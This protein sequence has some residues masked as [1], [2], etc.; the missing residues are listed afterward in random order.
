M[1][2]LAVD[3]ELTA[4]QC[5]L[6]RQLVYVF[7]G[8]GVPTG[9]KSHVALVTLLEREVEEVLVSR[10]GA[11]RRRKGCGCVAVSVF[12][13]DPW[14][15]FPGFWTLLPVTATAL[16]I[17]GGSASTSPTSRLLAS[18]PLVRGGDWS[19]SIYLWHWPFIVFAAYIW[20]ANRVAL[21]I[22]AV[23]SFALAVASD[24]WVE[25]PL[26]Q[27]DVQGRRPITPLVSLTLLP[28]LALCSFLALGSSQKRWTDWPRP[29]LAVADDRNVALERCS[30]SDFATD[31]FTPAECWEPE[32]GQVI[33]EALLL[34]DSQ[35]AA[36]LPAVV[37]A[38]A[39]S[40]LRTLYSAKPG[41]PFAD[42]RPSGDHSGFDCQ[43]WQNQSL[44]YALAA[45]PEVVVIANRSTGYTSP[46]LH[47]RVPLDAS[48]RP[49]KDV[50]EA[51]A[52]HCLC[53]PTVSEQWMGSGIGRPRLFGARPHALP[54]AG[55]APSAN[56]DYQ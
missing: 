23:V 25:Q 13:I 14:V 29:T 8:S 46:E 5:D 4:T 43:D 2:D 36:F 45:N 42:G 53:R 10:G 12:A 31:N 1:A 38:S 52:I 55:G 28:P 56:H 32:G 6:L 17:W 20:P 3:I 37:Q 15:P 27:A 34:G 26:R 54:L 40:G 48:G 49:T 9:L 11:C 41:C 18:K 35:A 39:R 47:W 7:R 19:Y 21:V 30:P 24:R 50:E 33:G 44:N 16:R 22:A 51:L